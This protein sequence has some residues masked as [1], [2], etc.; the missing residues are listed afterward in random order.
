MQILQKYMYKNWRSH[1]CSVLIPPIFV[2]IFIYIYQWFLLTRV[3]IY[4]IQVSWIF[5]PLSIF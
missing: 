1:N 5:F 4:Y 2:P 3:E